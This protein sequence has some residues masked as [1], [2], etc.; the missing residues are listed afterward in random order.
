MTKRIT[1]APAVLEALQQIATKAIPREKIREGNHRS[2]LGSTDLFRH[3][4]FVRHWV[5]FSDNSEILEY[6]PRNS[7]LPRVTATTYAEQVAVH[8]AIGLNIVPPGVPWQDYGGR[9]L[10]DEILT[11]AAS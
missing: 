3:G 6:N 1:H 11:E 7:D 10:F 9:G 4:Y 2:M 8:R 5:R